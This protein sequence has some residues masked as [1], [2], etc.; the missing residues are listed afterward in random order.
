MDPARA[1]YDKKGNLVCPSCASAATIAEGTSRATS[2]IFAT[3]IGV[4]VGGVGSLTVLNLFFILSIATLASGIGWLFTVARH[5]AYRGKMG[6]KFL[7]GLV[8]VTVGLVLASLPLLS[9][10]MRLSGVVLGH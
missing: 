6:S 10:A 3:A 4:L 9:T 7:V 5:P 8:A 1:T 2:S